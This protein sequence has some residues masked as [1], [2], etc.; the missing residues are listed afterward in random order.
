[1]SYISHLLFMI[2]NADCFMKLC[3]LMKTLFYMKHLNIVLQ[4]LRDFD[5]FKI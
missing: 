1:M 5:V 2:M 3:G 4:N